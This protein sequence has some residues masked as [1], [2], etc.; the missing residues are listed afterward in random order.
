MPR[1]SVW[2]IRLALVYLA[3][4]FTI[5]ALMLS[6]KG[7][8]YDASIWMLLPLHIEILLLGWT[9]QLI[10]GVGYWILP[11]FAKGAARGNETLAWISLGLL[12][13]GIWLVG[14]NPFLG[15]LSGTPPIAGR[16]LEASSAAL[17][18]FLSW[19]RIRP[20]G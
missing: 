6:Q 14:I 15:N 4:G 20:T 5:G 16:L 12:N 8:L 2:S 1:F 11:R 19:R 9:W 7:V 18:I 17:F 3:T 10:M 13:L